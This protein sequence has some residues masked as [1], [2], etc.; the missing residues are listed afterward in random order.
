[1]LQDLLIS[2]QHAAATHTATS[3]SKRMLRYSV[4]KLQYRRWTLLTVLQDISSLNNTLLQFHIKP[5]V[6]FSLNPLIFR[7][8]TPLP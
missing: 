1:M 2:R 6:N 3:H 7:K 5:I 8:P 4:L